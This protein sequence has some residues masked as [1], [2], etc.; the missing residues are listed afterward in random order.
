MNTKDDVP[1]DPMGKIIWPENNGTVKDSE[2][3]VILQPG[4]V[5]DRY[6]GTGGEYLGNPD[7]SYDK[8]SLPYKDDDK[9]KNSY[10]KYQVVR[11]IPA[12]EG[13]IAPYFGEK[14]GGTQYYTSMTVEE[15][16]EQGYIIEITEKKKI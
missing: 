9:A 12:V 3:E 10:H 15:L 1:R 5:L 8:R 16:L 6:G 13:T 2:H 11:P 14:G 7:D 4:T